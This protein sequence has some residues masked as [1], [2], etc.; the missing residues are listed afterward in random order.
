MGLHTHFRQNPVQ[1][2]G[3]LQVKSV[4]ELSDVASSNVLAPSL[5]EKRMCN[6]TV[7]SFPAVLRT[8][9]IQSSLHSDNGVEFSNSAYSL[10][11]SLSLSRN[12]VLAKQF[13][14]S[15]WVGGAAKGLRP[16]ANPP[17][18]IPIRTPVEHS[19]KGRF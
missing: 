13:R 1:P 10:S 7:S 12:D 15:N 6:L 18:P 17:F 2:L 5:K 9:D 19:V 8:Y 16:N 3:M 14:F 11:L 4:Q